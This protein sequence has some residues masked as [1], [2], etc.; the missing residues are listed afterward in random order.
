MPSL[1]PARLDAADTTRQ[2]D[3]EA[4]LTER[5]AKEQVAG[6]ATGPQNPKTPAETDP[7]AAQKVN[8]TDPRRQQDG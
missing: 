4:H 3:Y 1:S 7:R 8:P 5:D 2:I 6:E